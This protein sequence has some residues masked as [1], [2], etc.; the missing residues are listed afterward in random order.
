[1]IY[2]IN[3]ANNSTV[4]AR[5]IALLILITSMAGIAYFNIGIAGIQPVHI[6]WL[7]TLLVVL[8]AQKAGEEGSQKGEFFSR[9][10]LAFIAVYLLG[11]LLTLGG[12]NS[13]PFFLSGYSYLDLFI[14]HLIVPA[15]ILSA[16]WFVS[17][18]SSS[19]D[20]LEIVQ[21]S[22]LFG[23][24]INGLL[25]AIFYF[26]AGGLAGG[27][28]TY[29]PGRR[30]IADGMGLHSN[31]ISGV[32]VY[33]LIASLMMKAHTSPV[34]RTSAA[35]LSLIGIVLTFSRM[36]WYASAAILIL[37][38]PRMKWSLRIVI[39]FMLIF[40]WLQ[41][42]TQI[43][44]RVFYGRHKQT[45]AVNLSNKIDIITAGRLE[46]VWKPALN[47][48]KQNPIIGAGVFTRVIA[49]YGAGSAHNA[50]LKIL[51]NH[52]I[53]GMIIFLFVV[54]SFLKVSISTKSAFFYSII[55]MLIMGIV[56]HLF[57]PYRGNWLFLD[58]L[59]DE[60]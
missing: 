7:I 9:S 42:H 57:V 4:Q 29:N 35:G 24:I 3:S 52:G 41:F 56:G 20:D 45:E 6:L 8:S 23:A 43:K 22:I 48:F 5:F 33:F 13:H 47:Q 58:S 51:L 37:M 54:V 15:Q 32:C 50:Y 40:V 11:F 59:R 27:Y 60:L 2:L 39:G 16:G 36:A 34:L 44:N 28:S 10:L 30:A 12:G 21:K 25:I 26:D 19:R 14:Y 38:I 49:G 55:A 31:S 46:S 17:T 1:M 53:I 18:I